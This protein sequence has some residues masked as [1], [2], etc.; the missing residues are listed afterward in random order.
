MNYSQW[1][2][3]GQSIR[4]ASHERAGLPN[5]DAIHYEAI[6]L[7]DNSCLIMA[8]SDG[9]GGGTYF[10]S[11]IGAQHAV[12]VAAKTVKNLFQALLVDRTQ[13][14][15]LS[16]ILHQRLPQ[17][18]VEQWHNSVTAHLQANP[19]TQS[20]WG[21][22]LAQEYR[23][24]ELS[25]QIV[26]S[27]PV[28]AYGA[29]LLLTL[30]TKTFAVYFQLGDGDI[31]CVNSNGETTCPLPADD[32]LIANETISLCTPNAWKASRMRVISYQKELPAMILASTDGYT[33]SYVTK[34]D[35]LKIG[36]DYLHFL[37][38]QGFD[39]IIEQLPEILGETSRRGSGDDITLGVI[40]LEGCEVLDRNHQDAKGDSARCDE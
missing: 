35:F 4:G 18:L 26:E 3:N 31:L 14:S 9:H 8:I 30:V 33:N 36:S 24:G 37:R 10:R 23:D 28:V 5:Q 19:F 17:M 15:I 22:L 20:E 32:R 6:K 21:Q 2:C 7:E 13:F 12:K 1:H 38:H 34:K 29:T 11:H 27:N 16:Q 40:Y 39:Q 25:R